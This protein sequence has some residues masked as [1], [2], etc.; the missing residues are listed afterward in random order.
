MA[1][2][3]FSS[4]LSTSLIKHMRKGSLREEKTCLVLLPCHNSALREVM[5]GIQDRA[6]KQKMWRNLRAA[7]LSRSLQTHLPSFLHSSGSSISA[8][9]HHGRYTLLNQLKINTV[10]DSHAHGPNT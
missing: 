7:L 1:C 8:W 10:L 2:K 5:D 4:F 9:F 6:L 3:G